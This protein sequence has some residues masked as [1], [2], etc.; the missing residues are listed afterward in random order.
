[1]VM[2][3]LVLLLLEQESLRQVLGPCWQQHK[4]RLILHKQE[5]RMLAFRRQEFHKLVRSTLVRMDHTLAS[6]NSA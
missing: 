5:C 4:Q 3:Q 6:G 2:G 1:M